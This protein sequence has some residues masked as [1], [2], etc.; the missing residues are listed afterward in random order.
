MRAGVALLAVITMWLPL[1]ALPAA[2]DTDIQDA[3]G[4]SSGPVMS[5][6]AGAELLRRSPEPVFTAQVVAGSPARS[7]RWPAVV[8]L[9]LVA[10]LDG[11]DDQAGHFCGGTIIA[12]EWVLTAAHCLTDPTADG[13][14]QQL[15][16]SE[17]VEI[18][19]G[20]TKLT[21][22]TGT[23]HAVEA[24]LVAD[25]WWEGKIGHDIG[26]V[27]LASPTTIAPTDL[28]G[29]LN[30]SAAPPA[31]GAT[32]PDGTVWTI[33]WGS[34]V[35]VREEAL[36]ADHLQELTVPLWSNRMCAQ[37]DWSF[38]AET[39]ICAGPRKTDPPADACYGDSGG[40]LMRLDRRTGRWRQTGIVSR[41][42]TTSSQ[43]CAVP[44]EPTVYTHVAA[45]AEHI[46]EKT[47][48]EFTEDPPP[49]PAAEVVAGATRYSTSVA[50]SAAAYPSG[51]ETVTIAT[52]ASFGDAL[53]GAPAAAQYKGPLLLVKPGEVPPEVV[54]EIQRLD[55]ER[56]V[57]LGGE[58]AVGAEAVAQLE[59]L[60]PREVERLQGGTRYDTALAISR[61]TFSSGVSQVVLATGTDFA[62]ALTGAAAAVS[63]A[64][65]LLLVP[66]DDS[67]VEELMAEIRRLDPGRVLLLGGTAKV[68]PELEAQ[69]RAGL[70]ATVQRIAGDDR[71]ATAVAL[72]EEM[73]NKPEIVYLATGATFPDALSAGTLAGRVPGPLLLVRPDELPEP[74]REQIRMRQPTAVKI[75]G[76]PAAVQPIVTYQF[77]F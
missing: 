21:S 20:R 55:P 44:G 60:I 75:L 77:G 28:L 13:L 72:A 46:T 14:E 18:I 57:I 68:A 27:R 61:A 34:T 24:L 58:Q 3:E 41:A 48:V 32:A 45:F 35:P 66:G 17:L 26:L 42:A 30:E 56:I 47:G 10:E 15:V 40:P 43:T 2:A 69:L 19:A 63:S 54:A 12:P 8:S 25:G 53:A 6:D 9:N 59:A 73:T 67:V 50:A 31:S 36:G 74:V 16:P 7:G 22:A 71:Y 38:D 29:P 23:R 37:A 39:S 76:G 70:S 65:P 62:D 49:L 11:G 33:G 64:S 1:P 52:G 5:R 4:F 51:A